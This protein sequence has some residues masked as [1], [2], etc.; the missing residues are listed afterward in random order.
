[1]AYDV[2]K[3]FGFENFKVELSVRGGADNKGY[4]GSDEDW[5]RA[6]NALRTALDRRG[7]SYERIEG[8]AAF[9]GPKIDIKVEDSI[10]RLW[11]LSTVQFDF[12]LPE[13][14]GLEYIGEDNV[15]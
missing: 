5:S 1:F 2:F 11:Q 6:E 13:R 8:E 7:I 4:L 15:R 3:T 14:F 9:Y 10:G 12:N